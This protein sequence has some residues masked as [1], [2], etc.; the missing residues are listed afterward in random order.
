MIKPELP[1][2]EHQR[3]AAVERYDI[4][5]TPEEANFDNITAL[6]SQLTGAPVS[7]ITLLDNDRNFLKSHHGVPFSESPR[8]I[9]F[10]GH[11]INSDEPVTLIEDASQDVR[12]ADN[13]LVTDVGVR[14]YA[15]TPLITPDGYRLGTLCLFDMQPRQLNANQLEILQN[16]ARQVEVLLDLRYQNQLLLETQQQMKEKNKELERF[17]SVVTHDI[18]SPLVKLASAVEILN[19][20]YQDTMDGNALRMLDTIKASSTAIGNYV[21]DLLT[22][23][24]S[25]RVLNDEMQKIT[26]GELINE[27]HAIAIRDEA[28]VIVDQGN[29][30]IQI[31]KAAVLQILVNLATNS[32]K[33]NDKSQKKI[34]LSFEVQPYHYAF[35]VKDNGMGI[36]EDQIST[37]FDM[38]STCERSDAQGGNSQ[39]GTGLGLATVQKLVHRF[40]G[41]I[42]VT[43]DVGV[44]SKFRFTIRRYPQPK[45]L[46]MLESYAA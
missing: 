9:S 33:Y 21:D 15:G 37:I 27:V 18:K 24:T 3:Q 26:W 34:W 7:L 12:F 1:S 45:D 25:D 8:D 4:L 10:C 11:A 20:D 35:V 29:E 41:E 2:N 31:N 30:V 13:P 14:F 5:D 42:K 38:F 23:Y 43:S 16:M 22:Y 28:E 19:E 44:G 39:S 36:P 17:A 40:D 6:M 32:L 46:S